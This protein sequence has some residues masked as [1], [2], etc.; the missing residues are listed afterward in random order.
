M[1]VRRHGSVCGLAWFGDRQG[2]ALTLT[3]VTLDSFAAA[4]GLSGAA[5]VP[6][7]SAL[8]VF[9]HLMQVH[10]NCCAWMAAFPPCRERGEG[11]RTIA[12]KE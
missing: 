8:E 12:G 5:K 1:S 9:A 7:Q 11:D 6:M 2:L 10:T 4:P 3:Q